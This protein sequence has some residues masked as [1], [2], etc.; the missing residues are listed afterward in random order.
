MFSVDNLLYVEKI[1]SID[2]PDYDEIEAM[3]R[4]ADALEPLAEAARQRA[5]QWAISRFRGAPVG[6]KGSESFANRQTEASNEGPSEV[7]RFESFAELFEATRPNSEKEK[8][9]VA[10]YWA[11]VCESQSSFASQ[12]LNTEL[13]DL[14][15]GIGNITEALTSLKNDR[16]A[17]VLQLKKSGTSKQAR[18]TYKLTQEGIRRVQTMTRTG[19][20]VSESQ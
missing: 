19:N 14:G 6:D 4:I 8:A 2:M 5:L 7:Q 9:L 15:H 20:A 10:S 16:P 1:R 3:K 12:S 17:L 13:K 18:K 11:Q